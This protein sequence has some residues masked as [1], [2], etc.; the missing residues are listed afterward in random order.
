VVQQYVEK[1][2]LRG[3]DDFLAQFPAAA[4]KH[5]LNNIAWQLYEKGQHLAEAERYSQQS[6]E[7]ARNDTTPKP[8]RWTKSSGRRPGKP[9]KLRSWIRTAPFL[10]RGD[11][12]SGLPVL[13]ESV[14][15][16]KGNSAEVN[17]RYVSVLVQ[18]KRHQE[19]LAAGDQFIPEGKGTRPMK[20][21]LRSVHCVNGNEKATTA[22]WP[23]SKRRPGENE[24][25][26]DP[27]NDFPA[28]ALLP[29]QDLN[30]NTISSEA[31]KGKTVVVDFWATWCGPCVA[32]MPA[33]Q[34]AAAR[35]KDDPTVQFLFVNSWQRED[36]KLKL[37]RDFLERRNTTSPC[38]WTWTTR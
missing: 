36:D 33:M 25:G 17:E 13:K 23:R 5:L 12:R 27:Q 4:D 2:D 11:G 9:P 34:Q 16:L 10:P 1:E 7:L 6:L 3:A 26:A 29:L 21:D 14:R 18:T 35:Y 38:R 30:G 37:V 20:E 31:L 22:T 19:A 8:P 32:S 28:G 15:L 24:K